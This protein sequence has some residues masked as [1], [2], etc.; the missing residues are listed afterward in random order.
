MEV[1][2]KMELYFLF[3]TVTG[4]DGRNLP[5][6]SLD[7]AREQLAHFA[8]GLTVLP[9]SDGLWVS[10]NGQVVY[11][12]VEPLLVAMPAGRESEAWMVRFASE[13]AVL[14]E[15]QAVF[16]TRIPVTVLLLTADLAAAPA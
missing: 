14:L 13:L 2:A 5:A 11:D 16:L 4:N 3:L 6:Q 9:L 10:D 15:Q 12:D 1:Q 7:W 8:G